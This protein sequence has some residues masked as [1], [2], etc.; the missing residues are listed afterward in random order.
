MRWISGLTACCMLAGLGCATSSRRY[1][2]EQEYVR[3]R[4]ILQQATAPVALGI[5]GIRNANTVAFIP[6]DSCKEIKAAGASTQ[7]VDNVMRMRCGVVMSELE[8]QW[9]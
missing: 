5:E 8:R 9:L 3:N 4:D 6:P 2:V 7:E 1:T